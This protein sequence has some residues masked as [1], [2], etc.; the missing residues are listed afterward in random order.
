[1]TGAITIK[2]ACDLCQV[3]RRTMWS[4]IKANKVEYVKTAG[5]GIRILPASLFR[6]GN[7]RAG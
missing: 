3:S 4:W 6:Y 2:A 1:M 7:V 5:G